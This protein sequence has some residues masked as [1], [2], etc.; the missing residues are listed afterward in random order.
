MSQP[1]Y[2]HRYEPLKS[3][4]QQ[5]REL[6]AKL[7]RVPEWDGE[8]R[9]LIESKIDTLCEEQAAHERGEL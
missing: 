7:A 9:W 4:A 6:E 3:H 1:H 5:V 8:T 2:E